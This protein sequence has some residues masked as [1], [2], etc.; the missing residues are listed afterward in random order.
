LAFRTNLT[1]FF[2]EKYMAKLAYYRVRADSRIAVV[3]QR[4]TDDIT[5]L[6]AE[7]AHL[8]NHL[9][10]PCLDVL[11]VAYSLLQFNL[12]AQGPATKA[13][14]RSLWTA[15]APLLFGCGVIGVSMT[16]LRWMSPQ[17]GK[18]AAAR[19]QAEGHYRA[20]QSRVV[21]YAEEI[22][23][24]RGEAVEIAHLDTA[25]AAVV[26]QEELSAWSR[27]YFVTIEQF[28]LKCGLCLSP[29][30]AL[31]C[32]LCVLRGAPSLP[33]HLVTVVAVVD[34]THQSARS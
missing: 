18:Q 25:Y 29:A 24:L 20:T 19:S 5:K 2:Q 34:G 4:L 15:I 6:S 11:L 9:T 27:L 17:F 14:K 12:R 31:Q 26:K 7:T 3:D 33:S 28:F 1:T 13:G 30:L 8:Y 10:K 21:T 23:F 16:V 32:L 22:A